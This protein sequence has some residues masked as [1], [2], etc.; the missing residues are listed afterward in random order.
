MV[1]VN[2]LS[3]FTNQFVAG[4]TGLVPANT[5]ITFSLVHAGSVCRCCASVTFGWC[6]FLKIYIVQSSVA[7]RFVC[8]DIFKDSCITNCKQNV[9]LKS[10]QNRFLFGE[11][12]DKSLVAR[13]YG[14]R[15]VGM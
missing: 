12:M 2:K 11:N 13:F 3:T 4:L 15:C 5:M 1:T 8:D 9:S 14:S 6:I 7:T 10:F